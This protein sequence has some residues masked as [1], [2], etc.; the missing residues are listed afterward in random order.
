M[1]QIKTHKRIRDLRQERHLK[2][3]DL[4]KLMNVSAAVICH[5]ENDRSRPDLDSLAELAE[6][7]HTTT[8]YLIGVT[9]ERNRR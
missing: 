7:F 6:I 3:C 9:D 1:I 5:W 8:D 4:A 2:Q